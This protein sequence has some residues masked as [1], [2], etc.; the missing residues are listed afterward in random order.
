M[1][2]T[3]FTDYSLR[4]MMYA[5]AHDD[6]LV[7]IEEVAEVYGISRAHLMKVAN[8][9]T[10]SG[11][12]KSVRGRSGGLMLQRPVSEIRLGDIVRATE[13]NFAVVECLGPDNR[14]RITPHCR[15]RGVLAGAMSAFMRELD[16]RT[17][18]DLALRPADFGLAPAEGGR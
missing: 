17:L 4:M 18:H 12:L 8:L 11:F 15:L 5:A 2:L 14:C 16:A 7:T 10:R 9:L 13:P 3:T 1:R 6:R